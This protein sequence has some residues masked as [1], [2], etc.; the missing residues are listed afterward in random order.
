MPKAKLFQQRSDVTPLVRELL[1]DERWFRNGS[2]VF[3]HMKTAAEARD[4]RFKAIKFLRRWGPSNLVLQRIAARMA[5]CKRHQHCLGAACPVCGRAFQRAYVLLGQEALV[6][7]G[8]EPDDL[9]FVSLVHDGWRIER[10]RLCQERVLTVLRNMQYHVAGANLSLFIGGLD[11]S[12]NWQQT[13]KSTSHYQLQLAGIAGSSD[14]DYVNDHL[15]ECFPKTETVRRPIRIEDFDGGDEALA[16]TVKPDFVGR[17]SY[18]DLNLN[19]DDRGPSVNTRGRPLRVQE[20]IEVMAMLDE[21]GLA[22]RQ[23]LRGARF[24]RSEEGIRITIH[25]V[26]E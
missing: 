1:A 8:Y 20:R 2:P 23:F 4:A 26:D 5:S 15:R 14:W 10:G 17:E 13:N 7:A 21:L 16:Y 6:R 25:A 11:L 12:A 18:L 9:K 24:V 22:K 3:R 19:R